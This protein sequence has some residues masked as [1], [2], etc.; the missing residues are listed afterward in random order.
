MPAAGADFFFHHTTLKNQVFRFQIFWRKKHCLE[1]YAPASHAEYFALIDQDESFLN[2]SVNPLDSVVD[3][4]AE[5]MD[6]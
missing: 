6:I 3:E 2:A 1:E 5:G 4:L